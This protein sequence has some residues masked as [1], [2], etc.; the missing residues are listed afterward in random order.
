M[1]DCNHAEHISKN[2][3]VEVL[4]ILNREILTDGQLAC[5]DYTAAQVLSVAATAT[6]IVHVQKTE[7]DPYQYCAYTQTSC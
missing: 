6:A 4:G 7:F 5:L 1:H 2:T 3:L